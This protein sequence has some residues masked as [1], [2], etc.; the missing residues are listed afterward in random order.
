MTL[1]LVISLML[2]GRV[3][4]LPFPSGFWCGY[5]GAEPVAVITGFEDMTVMG[6]AIE[7]SRHHFAI[8]EDLAPFVE[9][10]IG[11]DEMLV[12]L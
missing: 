10:Q 1:T 4:R 2:W 8:A 12:H 9:A 6:Q 3:K 7:H 5:A 11:G